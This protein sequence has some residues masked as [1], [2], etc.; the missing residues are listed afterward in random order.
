MAALDALKAACPGADA[1]FLLGQVAQQATVEQAQA[2]WKIETM[3][4]EMEKLKDAKPSEGS[5]IKN[6]HLLWMVPVGL[7]GGGSFLVCLTLLLLTTF[8]A[9]RKWLGLR[10]LLNDDQFA[11]L[12]DLVKSAKSGRS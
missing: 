7:L 11:Q 10:P 1:E 3:R 12:T 2:A 9:I 6:L 5:P 4:R 8:R